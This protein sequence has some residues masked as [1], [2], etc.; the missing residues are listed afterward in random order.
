MKDIFAVQDEISQAVV[1]ALREKLVGARAGP[2]V[3]RATENPEAYDLYLKGRYHW[4]RWRADAM[5]TA[6]ELFERAIAKDPNFAAAWAGLADAYA[7]LCHWT[8]APREVW[9]K[10]KRAALQALELDPDLPE[11]H[12]A[13]GMILSFYEWDWQGAER[14]LRRSIELN[15]ASAIAH[16]WYGSHLTAVG[17]LDEARAQ[18]QQASSIDPLAIFSNGPLATSHYYL[19]E[20][21]RAIR[22]LEKTLDFDPTHPQAYLYLGRS[23][24]GARRLDEAVKVLERGTKLP[25]ADI[26]MRGI[27]GY[28]YAVM[29]K[30]A[31]AHRLL[32]EIDVGS[33]PRYPSLG[34]FSATFVHVGLGQYDQALDGL[35][36]LCAERSTL[37]HWVKV[38]LL[39]D[40]LRSHQRFE[41]ILRR[42]GLSA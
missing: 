13:L 27:L 34:V 6:A 17:S 10:A 19:R 29:G 9:E 14:A 35:E 20:Y 42:M 7:M 21:E 18:H 38:D 30:H 40:C 1:A 4:N 25:A 36:R 22:E 32:D 16:S 28:A 15:P 31:D 26:R 12:S 33:K 5:G 2:L 37:L 8:V 41:N 3:T 39:Y 23:Y 24:L 11:G